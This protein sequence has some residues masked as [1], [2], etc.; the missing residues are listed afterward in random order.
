[1][2]I[3]YRFVMKV[4]HICSRDTIHSFGVGGG[5]GGQLIKFFICNSVPSLNILD[6][7]V[8]ISQKQF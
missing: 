3:K 2:V 4:G 8:S 1:M 6:I 5:G 7:G